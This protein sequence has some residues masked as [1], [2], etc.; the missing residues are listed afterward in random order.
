MKPQIVMQKPTEQIITIITTTDS[1][2]IA[3]YIASALVEEKLA[4]CV[5]IDKIKSFYRWKGKVCH[6]KEFRLLIKTL[7]VNYGKIKKLILDNHNYELPPIIAFEVTEAYKDFASW[8]Y[9]E[10]TT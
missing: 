1:E 3:D 4:A 5:H 2:K 7:K 6:S 10:V 8:I 9:N